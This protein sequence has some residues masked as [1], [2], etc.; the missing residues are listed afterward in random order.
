MIIEQT[1]F[2]W[3]GVSEE[4][5]SEFR[6]SANPP[7]FTNSSHTN[8]TL[9]GLLPYTVYSFQVPRIVYIYSY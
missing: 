5:N 7:V 1:Y 8:Y 3:K 4:D 6:K 2:S 9:T